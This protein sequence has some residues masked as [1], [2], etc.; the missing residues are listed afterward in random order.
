[1][2]DNNGDARSGV[3]LN[4]GQED[5]YSLVAH[6]NGSYRISAEAASGSN[7]DT[8]LGLFSASGQRLAY[9]DDISSSNK[10]SLVVATLQAGARYYFGITNYTDTPIGT[11]VW[12]VDGPPRRS[13]PSDDTFEENDSLQ[14]AADL[15]TL[16]QRRTLTGLVMA[17]NADW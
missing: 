5:Y 13:G 16:T 14:Q 11:Y 6:A 3:R 12:A 1:A 8:V 9:D 17:D 2:L 4:F 10:D 7:I 15:G